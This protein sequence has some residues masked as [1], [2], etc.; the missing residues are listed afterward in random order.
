MRNPC[1]IGA[2]VA[3]AIVLGWGEAHA[4]QNGSGPFAPGQLYLGPEGGWS[5]SATGTNTGNL[6]LRTAPGGSPGTVPNIGTTHLDSGS[7][8][9]ARAGYKWGP[10]RF[11][12]E[13]N[14]R[15]DAL[16]NSRP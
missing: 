1:V 10:W 2:G 7:D 13:Y 6:T 12:E 15:N 5:R 14:H 9:G 3:L 11:E 4:Q 8:V 16:S